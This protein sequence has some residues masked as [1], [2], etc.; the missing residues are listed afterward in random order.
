MT[1]I[2]GITLRNPFMNASGVLGQTV[3]LLRRL[4]E[5]GAGA[6]VTKSITYEERKGYDN[7]TFVKIKCGY[8]NAM[9]LPNP[10][11]KEFSKELSSSKEEFKVPVIVSIAP[12]EPKQAKEMAATF[13]KVADAIEIN[14]SCPHAEKLGLEV[15]SDM[16][17]TENIVKSVKDN[18][19]GPV[20]CKL[21]PY[22]NEVLGL[23]KSLES[24][25]ALVVS[26]TIRAMVIDVK[27]KKPILGNKFGGLS[28]RA[29]HPISLAL[30]FE[31]YEKTRKP[32][33][34][35]GGIESWEDAVEFFLAGASAVQI[36]SALEKKGTTIF[37]ELIEGLEEYL[38]EEK[39]GLE[40]LIGLA[41]DS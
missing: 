4:Q 2:S 35:V 3:S 24:C 6:V 12:S 8:L 37:K 22:R 27:A 18:F 41:H 1:K 10:G 30:V 7:P 23:I 38:K 19:D 28:G 40:E 33:V 29:L 32:I 26:N 5:A 21:P 20:F 13:K 15:F 14:L 16:G 25:D 11:F 31:L 34:G 17:L 39:I 36:G 9:G